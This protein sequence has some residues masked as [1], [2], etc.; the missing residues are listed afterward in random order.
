MHLVFGRTAT[1]IADTC[2]P[3][4]SIILARA[5]FAS[6][7]PQDTTTTTTTQPTTKHHRQALA[8][9]CMSGRSS[10]STSDLF[11]AV[12]PLLV[13]NSRRISYSAY[14]TRQLSTR[15]SSR[16]SST[17]PSA[18]TSIAVDDAVAIIEAGTE[19][20]A[21][22]MRDLEA[23]DVVF[24]RTGGTLSTVASRHTIQVGDELHLTVD[25]DL[26]LMNHSCSPSCQLDIFESSPAQVRTLN[27]FPQERDP[28]LWIRIERL[29]MRSGLSH[30]SKPCTP[31]RKGCHHL[32]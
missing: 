18:V 4:A 25:N 29:K 14:S 15:S 13:G 17:A 24:D 30:P 28:S 1:G 22:A 6:Y 12:V 16:R 26:D 27:T 10:T 19:K 8:G 21:V 9:I 3:A 11:T 31:K 7:H 20:Y 23:G 32:F 5:G 2:S